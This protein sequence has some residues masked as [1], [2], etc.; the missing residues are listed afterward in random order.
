VASYFVSRVDTIVDKHL[1]ALDDPAATALVGKTAVANSRL[2]YQRYKEIFKDQAGEFADLAAAGAPVQ[3]LLWASTSTKN[4]AYPD[5]LYIDE[6]IGP[7][8][9]ST[10]PP[11]TIDAFRDHGTVA[12][13]LEKD[14]E[15]AQLVFD[16][17]AELNVDVDALTE[18]LQVDG[19]AAFAKSINSLLAAIAAKRDALTMRD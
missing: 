9:I 14:L 8:T 13:T 4:P 18:Q 1:A 16:H 3:R 12:Y 7:E 19:V 5:T 17:L 15:Q 11:A 6:L 10:M 2:V